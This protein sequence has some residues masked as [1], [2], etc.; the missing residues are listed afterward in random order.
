MT[1]AQTEDACSPMP[2]DASEDSGEG[3]PGPMTSM[4][5]TD[6]FGSLTFTG[7]VMLRRLP[8]DVFDKLQ[9]TTKHGQPLDPSIANTVAAAMKDWAAEYGATHFCHWFQPLTG[10]TAEK[11]DAFLSPDGTDGAISTISGEELISGEPDAS[12]FP[13]GG[14][15]ESPGPRPRII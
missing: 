8:P 2:W 15:R 14:I 1:T 10:T 9:A 6:V 12:S 4:T 3:L 7:D 5:P 11:H 13:S